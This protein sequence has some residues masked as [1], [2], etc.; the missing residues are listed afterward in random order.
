MA[1]RARVRAAY[2]ERLNLKM[3]AA[4]SKEVV[5]APREVLPHEEL[6][7]G[8]LDVA[9]ILLIVETGTSEDK[10]LTVTR[11]AYNEKRGH[12]RAANLARMFADD[13]DMTTASIL[14]DCLDDG[15]SPLVIAREIRAH[16]RDESLWS[17]AKRRIGEWF[18]STFG[19]KRASR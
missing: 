17:I 8:A 14:R 15:E 16:L 13:A 3:S 1:C 12:A 4:V 11:L 6:P 2:R 5:I 10:A 18:A 19:K 9:L 7:A